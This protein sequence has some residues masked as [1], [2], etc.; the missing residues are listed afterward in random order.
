MTIE[1]PGGFGRVPII[2]SG[3]YAETDEVI[4][5]CRTFADI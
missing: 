3:F 2:P 1:I 4:N 5:A